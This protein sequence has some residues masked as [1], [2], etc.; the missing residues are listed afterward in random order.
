M[1]LKIEIKSKKCGFDLDFV[2]SLSK[3]LMPYNNII[4]TVVY[5]SL[6]PTIPSIYIVKQ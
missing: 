1:D 5:I 3:S 4:K 2:K 6:T